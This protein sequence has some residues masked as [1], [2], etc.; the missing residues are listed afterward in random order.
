MNSTVS[1]DSQKL[2]P[3]EAFPDFVHVKLFHHHEPN[4]GG[5]IPFS[6]KH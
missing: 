4:K 6:S 1:I 3:S 2:M 5:C